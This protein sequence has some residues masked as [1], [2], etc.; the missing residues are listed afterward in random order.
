MMLLTPIGI[1]API[2]AGWIYD[3]TGSYLTAFSL[4]TVLLGVASSILFFVQPPQTPEALR[5]RI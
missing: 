5:K 3:T 1:A 2:Y 4:F